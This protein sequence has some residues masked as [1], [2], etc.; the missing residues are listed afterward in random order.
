MMAMTPMGTR[1]RSMTRPLGRSTRRITAPT[2]SGS[3]ATSRMPWA[4]PAMR[5]GVSLSRSSITALMWSFAA[6]MSMALAESMS[7]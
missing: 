1:V 3:A 2:G 6:S 7:A 4:M 5:S